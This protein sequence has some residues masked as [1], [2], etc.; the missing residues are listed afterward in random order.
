[1]R[2][3]PRWTL[4]G[5]GAI[6][7]AL[8]FTFPTWRKF[9]M[10][11]VSTGAFSNIS[12]AQQEVFA[13]M[14]KSNRDAAATA[15]FAM[16]TVVPAPT[17]EQPTPALPDA[18]AIKAGDFIELDAVHLGKGHATLYRSAD[19]SL[20]LRFDDFRVTNGPDMRIYLSGTQSPRKRDD[21][22]VPGVSAFPVGALKGSLGNQQFTIP[23]ELKIA[24]YKSVV[25][26]SESLSE[27][28]S[29]AP[30]Q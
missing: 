5:L 9:L 24:N 4:L 30:L 7:V 19:G 20:L 13:S 17:S 26:F 8:L 1:M 15:Y 25:I 12:A 28:Y 21:L 3:R 27:V 23:K 2:Y 29:S 22:D 16:L 10:G 6:V 14:S 11:R 18:Q